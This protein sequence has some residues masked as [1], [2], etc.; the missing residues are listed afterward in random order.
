MTD[1]WIQVAYL[2]PTATEPDRRAA[3]DGVITEWVLAHGMAREELADDDI[4][5]DLVYLGPDRGACATRVLI[6]RDRGAG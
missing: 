6:R 3:V 5:I 1:D 4:R 2:E